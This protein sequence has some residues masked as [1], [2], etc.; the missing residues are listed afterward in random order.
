MLFTI[1]TAPLLK[2]I[3]MV[4]ESASSGHNLSDVLCL[5]AQGNRIFATSGK[6]IAESETAVWEDGQCTLSRDALVSRLKACRNKA[7]VKIQADRRH[8]LVNGVSIPVTSYSPSTAS[9]KGFQV[10]MA[11]DLGFVAS[12]LSTRST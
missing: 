2:M 7:E 6:T 1:Q 4:G 12:N 11:S 5:A 8:L 10:F 9:P 3:Q